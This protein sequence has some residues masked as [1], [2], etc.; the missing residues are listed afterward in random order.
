MAPSTV[1]RQTQEFTLPIG[2]LADVA[3]FVKLAACLL[4][5]P[6]AVDIFT[7]NSESLK[8]VPSV[9]SATP[10]VRRWKMDYSRVMDR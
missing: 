3:S 10:S 2:L 5:P 8:M 9:L 6:H 7:G 4:T 1:E